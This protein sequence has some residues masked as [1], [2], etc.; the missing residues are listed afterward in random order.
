MAKFSINLSDEILEKVDARAASANVTRAEIIRE[1]VTQGNTRAA[2]PEASG[3]ATQ[4]H[5]EVTQLQKEIR[6][7]EAALLEER[8][9]RIEDLKK[10][11]D[12]QA[13]ETARFQVLLQ[14]AQAQKAIPGPSLGIVGSLKALIWGRPK[15]VEEGWTPAQPIDEA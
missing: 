14:G 2:G 7:L 8:A 6:D 3:D 4:R 1:D 10:A 12:R 13:Q 15:P 5:P 9:G 11:Q